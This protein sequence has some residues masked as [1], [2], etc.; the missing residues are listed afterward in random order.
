MS[1]QPTCDHLT[2]PCIGCDRQVCL[3]RDCT[4]RR[5]WDSDGRVVCQVC[6]DELNATYDIVRFY[7][8]RPGYA[9]VIKRN[10]SLHQARAHCSDPETSSSTARLADGL[11]RTRRYGPWFDGYRDAKEVRR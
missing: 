11:N 3:D 10:V 2:Q 8:N 9:Q 7:F 6:L 1:D 4:N 5:R